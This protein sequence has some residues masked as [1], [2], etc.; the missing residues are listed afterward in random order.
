MTAIATPAGTLGA[1]PRALRILLV[2]DHT[3]LRQGLRE[4]L[5]G[6]EGL[7]VVGEAPDGRRALELARDLDFDV[8]VMDLAM[9][10]LDGIE[11]TRRMLRL[12]PQAKVL[13]LS[14]CLD[15][16][17]GRAFEAGASGYALKNAS[18]TELI[19]AVR[20]VAEGER[21]FAPQVPPDVVERF[22]KMARGVGPGPWCLTPREREILKL[23]AEGHT[24]KEVAR[25]LGL[26][27]KTVDAHKTS[28]MRKLD[29]HNRAALVRYAVTNK[30]IRV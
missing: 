13:I 17:V 6:E 30:L 5:E 26:S 25:L 27:A 28:F 18:S 15:E 22:G 1:R 29:I 23:L 21:Y 20:A 24:G 16:R 2:D 12:K 3:I 8:V 4:L 10:V 9:P 14:M 19:K 7:S 11:A